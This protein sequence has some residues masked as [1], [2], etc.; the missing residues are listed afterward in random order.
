MAS[1][2]RGQAA[3]LGSPLSSSEVRSHSRCLVF[4]PAA[5]ACRHLPLSGRV[6]WLPS[7]RPAEG[8]GVA[9]PACPVVPDTAVWKLS[10]HASRSFVRPVLPSTHRAPGLPP[11]PG[12]RSHSRRPALTVSRGA[13]CGGVS[14]CS[15]PP[16]LVR[17]RT[18][19]G[20]PLSSSSPPLTRENRAVP[21]SGVRE[22]LGNFQ[23]L[24]KGASARKSLLQLQP[25]E[26]TQ[27]CWLEPGADPAH[28]ENG[29]V[30]SGE[31]PATQQVAG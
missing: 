9:A 15:A 28:K 14:V 16:I 1:E 4:P 3:A 30:F 2:G 5:P 13:G 23:G 24:G 18:H 11:L 31:E 26:E 7:E 6:L 8:H 19:R 22:R 25:E 17:G 21:C 20:R 10:R 27:S 12:R 29:A